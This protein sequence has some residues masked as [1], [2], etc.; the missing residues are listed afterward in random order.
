MKY[1]H[2]PLSVFL[3]SIAFLTSHSQRFEG[4]Y[5]P[6]TGASNYATGASALEM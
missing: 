5:F 6:I 3:F 4:F 1:L 2:L